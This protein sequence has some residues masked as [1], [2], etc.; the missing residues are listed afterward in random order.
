MTLRELL[1]E[2]G[3]DPMIPFIRKS[4]CADKVCYFK[5]AYDILLHTSPNEKGYEYVAVSIYKSPEGKIYYNAPQLEGCIWSTYID[6]EVIFINGNVDVCQADLAFQLLYQLTF[7][8]YSDKHCANLF[9]DE[10]YNNKYSWMAREVEYKR[11]MAWATNAVR[12]RVRASMKENK[13]MGINPFEI[14][15]DDWFEIYKRQRSGRCNRMK[16]KR[17]YRWGKRLETLNEL[18][19]RENPIYELLSGQI[20]SVTRK[21]LLFLWDANERLVRDFQTKAYDVKKRL[22]YLGE[23]ITKYDALNPLKQ[24]KKCVVKITTSSDYPLSQEK[25][26]SIRTMIK[27]WIADENPLVMQGVDESLGCELGIF[28]IGVESM[29]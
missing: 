4:E 25:V 26:N 7:Y 18:E 1:T 5:L 19:H 13:A 11:D 21:D 12:R 9:G 6:G 23:L 29:E 27:P 15:V 16:R 10:H 20:S 3:F 24:V 2:T 8:G 28:I 14:S 17:E 22:T